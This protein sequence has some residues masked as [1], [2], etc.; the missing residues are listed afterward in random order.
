MIE[1]TRKL[2]HFVHFLFLIQAIR[3]IFAA[4]NNN[5]HHVFRFVLTLF[6]IPSFF[7]FKRKNIFYEMF[8]IQD[9]Y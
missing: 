4:I 7:Y 6:N 5:F 3:Y 8:Y 2:C 1:R 9:V